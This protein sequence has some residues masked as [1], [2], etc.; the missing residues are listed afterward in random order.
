MN[1]FFLFNRFSDSVPQ[2]IFFV[3]DLLHIRAAFWLVGM[4]SR[5]DR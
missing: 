2:N 5:K 4:K 3:I 1:A